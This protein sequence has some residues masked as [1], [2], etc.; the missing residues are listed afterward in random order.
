MADS[1]DAMREIADLL[2]SRILDGTYAH[3]D[4]IPSV[5][6]LM[7]EYNVS[8]TT[9]LRAM[10][11]LRAEGL[12]R[13]RHGAGG[14][15]TR[16]KE[17]R[18]VTPTRLAAKDWEAGKAI[19]DH[20]TMPR[21]RSVTIDL[22]EGPAPDWAAA[23]LGLNAGDTAA[24][25]VRRFLVDNRPVQLSTSY[26]PAEL[27]RG[28]RIMFMD[29]GPGG[30]YAR[31]E[32]L[33]HKPVQFKE[34]IVGRAPLPDEIEQLDLPTVQPMVLEITREAWASSGCVEVNRMVLD[35]TAYVVVNKFT[36]DDETDWLMP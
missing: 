21:P 17:I 8:R 29:T 12:I 15:V 9:V 16:F 22:G 5:T 18:R 7:K 20:D 11:M 2:R 32:E 14:Y 34:E 1:N 4:K 24:F 33:G 35:A 23:A 26:F 19:Q 13:I 31:L 36:S 27:V 30:S 10:Y 6:E 28:T 3:D 25:R